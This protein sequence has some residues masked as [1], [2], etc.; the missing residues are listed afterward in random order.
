VLKEELREDEE[1][2]I[3][4]KEE[5]YRDV[6]PHQPEDQLKGKY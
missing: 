3:E 1:E 4:V 2:F 6:S 5:I